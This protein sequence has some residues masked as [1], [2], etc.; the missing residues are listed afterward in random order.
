MYINITSVSNKSGQTTVVIQYYSLSRFF[1]NRR[2]SNVWCDRK[3]VIQHFDLSKE[4]LSKQSSSFITDR[5]QS[6]VND[7]D[8]QND[9]KVQ[10]WLTSESK[11]LT[12]NTVVIHYCIECQFF[13]I[14]RYCR[15]HDYKFS[16]FVEELHPCFERSYVTATIYD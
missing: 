14:R 4:L 3:R 5:N 16:M 13:W 1:W 2:Y 9:S 15:S 12:L 6:I 8:V 11:K 7:H 10:V